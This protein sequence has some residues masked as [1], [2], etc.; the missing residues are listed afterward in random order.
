M[1]FPEVKWSLLQWIFKALANTD[2]ASRTITF[3][4]KCFPIN[5]RRCRSQRS[6]G[7]VGTWKSSLEHQSPC[8][9]IR[10]TSWDIPKLR[11]NNIPPRTNGGTNSSKTVLLTESL[12]RPKCGSVRPLRASE[13]DDRGGRRVGP[14][15]R[16]R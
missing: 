6:T 5:P 16:C 15:R 11:F 8:E 9:G 10:A 4:S 2:H 14:A 12:V 1:Y 3:L 7:H 13:V